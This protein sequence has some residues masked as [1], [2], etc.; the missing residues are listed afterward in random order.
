MVCKLKEFGKHWILDYFV[1]K[2]LWVKDYFVSP[3]YI[4]NT[5]PE[6]ICHFPELRFSKKKNFILSMFSPKNMYKLLF[7][8]SFSLLVKKVRSC[9][10]KIA[11]FTRLWHKHLLFCFN[12][13]DLVLELSMIYPKLF[14]PKRRKIEYALM[15][16]NTF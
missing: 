4:S 9:K 8:L 6:K 13:S 12:C 1:K 14:S 15:W 3:W 10:H 11:C 16:L 2:I 7:N 5:N